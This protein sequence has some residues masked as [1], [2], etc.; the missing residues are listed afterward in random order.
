MSSSKICTY[1]KEDGGDFQCS[2]CKVSFYCSRDCQVADWKQH[3]IKCKDKGNQKEEKNNDCNNKFDD[4]NK[5]VDDSKKITSEK[6]IVE[7][8]DKSSRYCLNCLKE[9]Q[10]SLCCSR[11]LT[12]RYCDQDC[13]RSHWPA[14]KNSC[15]D[16]NSDISLVTLSF[17]AQNYGKQDQHKKAEKAYRKLLTKLNEVVDGEDEN[18]EFKITTMNALASCCTSNGKYTEADQILKEISEMQGKTAGRGQSKT[19]RGS[20]IQRII[21]M[22]YQAHNCQRQNNFGQAEIL[23]KQCIDQ[24]AAIYGRDHY[25]SIEFMSDLGD[26]YVYQ[27]YYYYHYIIVI[28]LLLL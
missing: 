20:D 27:G 14:H 4:S 19:G 1:C 12:A 2:K 25:E 8:K 9:L 26:I 24:S 13:Q 5:K 23:L 6:S 10:H 22:Q 11:C 7:E 17:K 3:K 16:S 28:M 18:S 21:T 15:H